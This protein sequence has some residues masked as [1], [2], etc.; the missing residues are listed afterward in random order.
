MKVI[1]GKVDHVLE[2]N[3]DSPVKYLSESSQGALAKIF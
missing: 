2:I 3:R 1:H